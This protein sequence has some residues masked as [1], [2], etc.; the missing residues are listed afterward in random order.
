MSDYPK[1][2]DV[3]WVALDPAIGSETQKTKPYIIISNDAQNKKSLRTIIAPVT[4]KVKTIYPF[5]TKVMVN[6]KEGKAML[7]QIKAVDKKR[8]GKKICTVS[9]ET[10]LEIDIALKI[11]LALR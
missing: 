1:R 10:L 11:A 6:G 2:G 7:D 9:I 5:E 8:L 3:Y 4:S